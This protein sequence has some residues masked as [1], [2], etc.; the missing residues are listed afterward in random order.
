MIENIENLQIVRY[1]RKSS[2]AEDRQVA[3]LPDQESELL[4]M[5]AKIGFTKEQ[6]VDDI[7][8]AR[9]AKCPG[10]KGFD[11]L[12]KHIKGGRVNAISVW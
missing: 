4:L 7:E 10:R 2:E 6:I 1:R 9:S 12:V 5:E 3:S 8:E 11:E